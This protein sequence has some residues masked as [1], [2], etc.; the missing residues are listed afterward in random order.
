MSTKKPRG[1]G[2]TKWTTDEQLAYL[3]SQKSAYQAA[4]MGGGSKFSNF[5]ASVYEYWFQHWPPSDLTDDEKAKGVTEEIK[6]AGI[7][8]VSFFFVIQ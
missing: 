6:A 1:G 7:K 4:Q 2:S 8:A 5:W 3:I